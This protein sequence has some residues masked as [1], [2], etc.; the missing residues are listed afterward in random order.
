M[1]MFGRG[2]SSDSSFRLALP[3]LTCLHYSLILSAITEDP[4]WLLL[5]QVWN[6][7]HL[8]GALIPFGGK[9]NLVSKIWLCSQ[10]L[11]SEYFQFPSE[12][13][14]GEEHASVTQGVF[15]ICL[16]FCMLKTRTA[17]WT[18]QSYLTPQALFQFSLFPY[19]QLLS[20]I[21]K[22]ELPL[23][24]SVLLSWWILYV[25]NLIHGSS[26]FPHGNPLD[27]THT[28]PVSGCHCHV[29]FTPLGL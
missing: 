22:Y 17:H 25:I 24:L 20:L 13:S 27:G 10:L 7:T 2:L 3:F 23:F 19:L 4:D 26:F 6:Q 14:T 28:Q 9:Y 8:Q 15:C 16:Y 18:S 5:N 29:L 21:V 11:V 1:L 12:G